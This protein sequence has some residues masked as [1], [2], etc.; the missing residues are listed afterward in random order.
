[1]STPT[2][3]SEELL[4]APLPDLIRELGLAVA[5]ANKELLAMP[6]AD[7]GPLLYTI[8]NAEIELKVAISIGKDTTTGVSAGGNLYG[9]A[10]NASYSRTYSFKEEA[11]STIKL[12]LAAK[13]RES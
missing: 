10:L 1:M 9:F 11:S 3:A 6:A 2:R 7:I 13:P 8:N 12:T 4:A 5:T